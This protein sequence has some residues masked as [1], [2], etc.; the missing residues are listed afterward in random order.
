MEPYN[1]NERYFGPQGHWLCAFIPEFPRG[2]PVLRQKFN[3]PAYNHD[4][5]Y[6]GEKRSGFM[7]KIRDQW[8]RWGI[9]KTFLREM[10]E[11]INQDFMDGQITKEQLR[12]AADYANL[13]YNAVRAFGWSF[14]RKG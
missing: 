12:I 14:F 8:E 5:G 10:N 2:M 4:G 6:E 9:D 11:G 13:A 3:K 1:P 7:G